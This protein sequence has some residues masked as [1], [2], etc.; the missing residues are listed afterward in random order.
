MLALRQGAARAALRP[1]QLTRA[2]RRYGSTG[3]HHHHHEQASADEPLGTGLIIAVAGLPLSCLLYF[4]ARR[5]E[6][7]EEPA[8]TRWLRKYQ[9]L[10]E[11]WLERNTLH[12][13]AV[14]QAAADKLLFLT[15]PE[16]PTTSS[17]IPRLST[18]T[19]LE[20]L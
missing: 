6:N 18:L 16:P 5:G 8:I 2:T 19:L 14:Q 15:A 12:S 1:I 20:T 17:G 7:G 13:Q 4:A 9:S 11:V 10:N 3:G